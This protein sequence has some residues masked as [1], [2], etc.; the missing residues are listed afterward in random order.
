MPEKLHEKI[1][2]YK[3]IAT[4]E[5]LPVIIKNYP[6][7]L[8]T[9]G[10]I[11]SANKRIFLFNRLRELGA[12]LPVIFSPL[13]YVSKHATVAEGI[14]VMHHAV[15][16]AGAY[17]GKN[18]IINTKMGTIVTTSTFRYGAMHVQHQSAQG[19]RNL[20]DLPASPRGSIRK[21]KKP[22]AYFAS[23]RFNKERKLKM[24]TK[25]SEN[26]VDSV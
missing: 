9:V 23:S 15:V 21:N 8:I 4:D 20:T 1:L 7:F 26:F 10:Q 2:G 16:N 18:C 25:N 24:Q 17:F 19:I 13:S 3:I 14:I 5:D 22:F 12:R 6:Y 11:R